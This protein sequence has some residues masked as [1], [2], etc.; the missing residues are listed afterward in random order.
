MAILQIEY[1][2]D[3]VRLSGLWCSAGANEARAI[4]KIGISIVAFIIMDCH[5][6][7]YLQ[8][9]LRTRTIKEHATAILPYIVCISIP[10]ARH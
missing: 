5:F 6:A 2:C 3:S 7:D 10:S 4:L 8:Y 9:N 1:C